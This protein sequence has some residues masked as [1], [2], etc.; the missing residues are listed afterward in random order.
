M[1]PEMGTKT[2]VGAYCFANEKAKKNSTVINQVSQATDLPLFFNFELMR[3]KVTRKWVDH[4]GNNHLGSKT[5]SLSAFTGLTPSR[6]SV[7]ISIV[8]HYDLTIKKL[9]LPEL[10]T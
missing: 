6:N 9:N 8:L 2:T 4:F 1:G 5:K 10:R 7:G 3:S